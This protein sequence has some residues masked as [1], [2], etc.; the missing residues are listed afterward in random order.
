MGTWTEANFLERLQ[1]PLK[2]ALEASENACPDAQMM[3]AY[4][5][6]NASE[7][8]RNAVGEHLKMC[9]ECRGLAERIA[10]FDTSAANA[11]ALSAQDQVEWANAEKRLDIEAENYARRTEV[12]FK[13]AAELEREAPRTAASV[14]DERRNPWVFPWQKTAWSLAAVAAL[15]ILGLVLTRREGTTPRAAQTPVAAVSPA[16]RP[17]VQPPIAVANDAGA[18]AAVSPAGSTVNELVPPGTSANGSPATSAAKPHHTK[19]ISSSP[20]NGTAVA[21]SAAAPDVPTSPANET[22]PNEVASNTVPTPAPS[23]SPHGANG[24]SPIGART[25]K[26]QPSPA[27]YGAAV[28]QRP[29]QFPAAIHLISGTRVWITLG[30]VTHESDANFAFTGTLFEPIGGPGNT[31]LDKTTQ[32]SGTGVMSGGKMAL[33]IKEF[34]LWDVHYRLASAT[35]VANSATAG[36]G[37][38]VPFNAGQVQ[39]MWLAAAADYE[40]VAASGSNP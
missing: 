30:T 14:P 6:G 12:N 34:M 28:P 9:A 16:A 2:G 11:A 31:S 29:T 37:A 23:S 5:A 25:A 20:G 38:A 36:G 4:A 17:V 39:E 15:V 8:V 18:N 32:V 27:E 21:S 33:Y 26:S 22:A 24:R 10:A 3:E 13:R 1:T 35:G 19:P 7:F 40:K